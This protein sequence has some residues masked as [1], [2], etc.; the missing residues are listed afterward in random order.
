VYK[1][2]DLNAAIHGKKL[3]TRAGKEVIDFHYF[4]GVTND[5]CIAATIKLSEDVIEIRNLKANGRYYNN[6]IESDYDLFMAPKIK[7]I[8]M[9]IYNDQGFYAGFYESEEIAIAHNV[10]PQYVK[11]ISFEVEE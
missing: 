1:D 11:T 3:I 7:K 5:H 4:S 9:N 6:P 2:F 10:H 8:W